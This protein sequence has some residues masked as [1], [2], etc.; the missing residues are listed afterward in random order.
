MISLA[1]YIAA[2]ILFIA[3]ILVPHQALVPAGLACL[4]AAHLATKLG[5]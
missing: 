3:S 4:A 5:T 1:F 2:I